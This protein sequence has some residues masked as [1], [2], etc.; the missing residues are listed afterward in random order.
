MY[1]KYL[2]LPMVPPALLYR[3]LEEFDFFE[4]IFHKPDYPFYKQYTITN[5]ALTEFI[6]NILEC[7]NFA[8]Y[9]LIRN[10]IA[11]HKDT[12]RSEVLNY[13]VSTGGPNATL[14]IFDDR[15][16]KIHSEII[17]E[18]RWHWIDVSVNHNVTN[19]SDVRVALTVVPQDRS[20][21]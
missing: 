4:N 1:F 12:G 17:E 15:Y 2:N 13:L 21:R 10:G 9:Q 14:N 3:S 16:K 5:P 11:I 20:F 6:D 7:R 19:F 8:S 18:K